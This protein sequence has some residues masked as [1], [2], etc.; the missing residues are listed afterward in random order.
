M[1]CPPLPPHTLQVLQPT[2]LVG[3][4]HQHPGARLRPPIPAM[5]G[6]RARMGED[7]ICGR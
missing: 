7:A 5:Q 2:V 6:R 1:P 3:A 4:Q